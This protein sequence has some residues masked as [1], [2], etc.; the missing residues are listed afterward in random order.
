MKNFFFCLTLYL[1][2]GFHCL[3]SEEKSL[4]FIA[5]GHMYPI[6]DDKEIMKKLINKIN[7]HRPDFVFILGDSKLHDLKYLNMFKSKI[8]SK[9]FFSPGNHE[10]S[11]FKQEYEKKVGYLNTIIKTKNV[12]FLLINSS[13]DIKNIKS[14]LKQHLKDNFEGYRIILTHHRIWDDTLISPNSYGHDKSFYFEDIYPI[15]KKNVNAIIAGNSKRQHFRDLTDD[16][17]SYGKQNVNLI[18]WLDKIGNI[19]LYAVGMGDGKPKANFIVAEVKKNNMIINGDYVSVEN[20]DVLPRNLIESNQI[21]FTIHNTTAIRE[22]VKNKYFLINKKKTYLIII[23]IFL[24]IF[25]LIYRIRKN[26]KKS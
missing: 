5:L 14:F 23:I 6:I 17:F 24:T 26:E 2:M 16:K 10:L 20:Y 19:D 9:I 11:R 8:N 1:I 15:I 3:F 12:E 4:K 13:D 21:R 22:L 7:S 25:Y 18:Y